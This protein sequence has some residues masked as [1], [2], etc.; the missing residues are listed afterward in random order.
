MTA[1]GEERGGGGLITLLTAY[2]QILQYLGWRHR[3]AEAAATSV[4]L[5]VAIFTPSRPAFLLPIRVAVALRGG[6]STVG[7]P[8]RQ[9][10]L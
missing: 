8:S 5:T 9:T 7:S 2:E 4:K 1:P 3:V 10:F 6:P